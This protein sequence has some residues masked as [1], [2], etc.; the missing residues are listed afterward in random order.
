MGEAFADAGIEPGT[1]TVDAVWVGTVFGP[2][3]VAQRVLRAMGI[4]GVPVLTV[5]NACASG[6]TAFAEATR[7]CAPALRA[8]AGAGTRADERRVR[9]AI[10]PEPTDPRAAPGWP[11][12]RC[13]R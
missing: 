2:A 5:E 4:T 6:T 3:G 10:T 8:G 9:G 11:C 13:T 7:R 12:R 1:D